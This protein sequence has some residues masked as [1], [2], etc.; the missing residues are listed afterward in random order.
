MHEDV[1]VYLNSQISS[2]KEMVISSD[3]QR[4]GN[5]EAVQAATAGPITQT[6]QSNQ[7]AGGRAFSPDGPI[8]VSR[9]GIPC[10]LFW[11]KRIT[12]TFENQTWLDLTER[13]FGQKATVD[14]DHSHCSEESATLYLNFGDT[15]NSK[16]LAMRLVLGHDGD[17]GFRL[18]RL[19]LLLNGS[20][21]AAFGARAVGAPA[22]RSFRC[23]RVS[24]QRPDALLPPLP[25]P[26][27]SW[28][29]WDVTLRGLQLQGFAIQ[30][31][32]FAKARDC[33]TSTSSPAVLLGL[34]MALVLLLVL[35]YA[36]HMLIYLRHLD[37]HYESVA[38]PLHFPQLWACSGT[39]GKELLRSQAPECYELQGQQNY[40]IYV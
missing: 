39:E 6:P 38:S 9:H 1:H 18:L 26:A 37:Q 27:G 22:G 36:L 30:G 32:Q 31:G 11:A 24:S 14:T 25:P 21:E 34:A 19:E 33:A 12:V 3:E 23:G 15:R 16:A 7:S 4:N 8:R 10:I 40:R 28:A 13:A 29:H 17:L 20:T 2:S 35:A 5:M